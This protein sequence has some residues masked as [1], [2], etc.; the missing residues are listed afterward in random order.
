M[1]IED[2]RRRFEEI[3][4]GEG[5]HH[6]DRIAERL[7]SS[8]RGDYDDF[9]VSLDLLFFLIFGNRLHR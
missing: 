5:R 1:V 6:R 9:V 2:E 4:V 3:F 7:F 8:C